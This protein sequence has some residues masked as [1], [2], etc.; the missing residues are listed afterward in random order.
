MLPG[1]AANDNSDE[2]ADDDDSGLDD[3]Q[4][5]D[6][7]NDD[8]VDNDDDDD[9]DDDAAPPTAISVIVKPPPTG[10]PL[11]RRVVVETNV[12]CSLSG[13]VV[14][15]TE[16]GYGLSV[17]TATPAATHHELWFF[18]LLEDLDFDFT[19]FIAGDLEQTLATG[20]FHVPELPDLNVTMRELTFD[21]APPGT[22]WIAANVHDRDA[23]P[24]QVLYLTVVMDRQG[25]YRFFHEHPRP[26]D[27][28]DVLPDGNIAFSNHNDIRAVG[29]NGTEYSLVRL[30]VDEVVRQPI[31][32]Q[33]YV[34]ELLS[35]GRAMIIFNDYGPGLECDLETPT[36]L[37][38]ADGYRLLDADGRQLWRWSVFDHQDQI[39]P[40]AMEPGNC[41]AYM[42]GAEDF[43]L[44]HSNSVV[45]VPGED[46]VLVS[47]RNTFRLV[48]ID[49][50]SGDIIW[51]MGPDMGVGALD[52]EY[53]SAGPPAEDWF[54]MTHNA[55]YV[56]PNRILV[57]DNSVCRYQPNC[58]R[59]RWSRALEIEVDE[60]A[61]TVT[62]VWEHRVEFAAAQGN[63]E[64]HADGNT[65]ICSGSGRSVVE[66]APDGDETFRVKFGAGTWRAVYHAPMWNEQ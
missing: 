7:D 66:V 24:D 29:R 59:G 65:L 22:S 42:L 38:V 53:V 47:M 30:D 61:R 60:N 32:H 43:D 55:Q 12:P 18:G 5:V 40:T 23:L 51:Q 58:L 15:E 36:D 16:P 26:S 44:T 39:P 17:P 11:A 6:D 27:W 14:T 1:C 46:A 41:E 56:G 54:R 10:N 3:D 2:A 52:F 49:M 37:A 35:A 31:H 25:R 33:I 62:P 48:K 20:T 34:R 4:T 28:I 57:F 8:M 50:T 63:V 21:D 64:R 9:N 19:L 45:P 13:Y